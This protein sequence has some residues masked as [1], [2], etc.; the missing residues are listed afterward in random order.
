MKKNSSLLLCLVCML[1]SSLLI[2]YF[3]YNQGKKYSNKNL[4][5]Y[6]FNKKNNN[7]NETIILDKSI[8]KCT[9]KLL[10]DDKYKLKNNTKF[11][12]II[13]KCKDKK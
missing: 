1:F 13:I 7:L 4:G 5:T 12:L 2:G 6:Y 10:L 8:Y 3:F 9:S 11:R